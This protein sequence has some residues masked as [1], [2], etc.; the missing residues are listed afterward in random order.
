[1]ELYEHIKDFTIKYCDSDFRDELKTSVALALM[2]EVACSSADELGFGYAFVKPRGY[3]FMVTN[4]C[5]EFLGKISLGDTV[6]VKT[7]PLPP[8]RVTFGREYCFELNGERVINASS[9]WCLVDIKEGKILQSKLIEN[10]DYST[11]N[12]TRTIEDVSWKIPA[13]SKEEGELCY[14]MTVANSEY[15]HNMHVNNTRYADYCLNCFS[16]AELSSRRL[17]RLSITYV[18]QCKEGDRLSFYRKSVEDGGYLVQGFNG[19]GETVV[20]FLLHFAE[21]V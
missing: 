12:T 7:W 14:E 4:I 5:M 3:A 15:D 13:F 18:R 20:Q 19:D 9:R 6:R 8:T 16:L 21:N 17:K 1:M 10:Q 11:Y 2:E